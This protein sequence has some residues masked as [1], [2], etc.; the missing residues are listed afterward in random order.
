MTYADAKTHPDWK[1][2]ANHINDKIER[3]E[4]DLTVSSVCASPGMT[5]DLEPKVT[6]LPT[7]NKSKR[8]DKPPSPVPGQ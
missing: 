7:S 6:S 2:C 4:Q 3:K 8:P 5:I 1:L